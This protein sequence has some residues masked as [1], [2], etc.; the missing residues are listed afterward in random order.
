MAR[1]AIAG[2]VKIDLSNISK[3]KG[4]LLLRLLRDAG[5]ILTTEPQ[6]DYLI[7]IDHNRRDYNA[8]IANGGSPSRSILIRLE[9]PSVFPSQ[10]KNSISK[11]YAQII[12]PGS[13]DTS[14][15]SN[16]QVGWPY[17]YH[18]NPNY[19][20]DSGP[21][22][23]SVLDM[24][25]SYLELQLRN[26]KERDIFVSMIASNKVSP[27]RNE[28]YSIR[29]K[30]AVELKNPSPAVYGPLWKGNLIVK[31]HHRLAV[32]YFS[33]RQGVLP[34][35]R[36]IYGSLFRKYP[37]AKGPI[38]NKHV[39]LQQSKFTLVVE[40]SNITVTEKLF[41]ALV[42]GAVP[43]Y[44]GPDLS[45]VGLPEDIALHCDGDPEQIVENLKKVSQSEIVTILKAGQEFLRSSLFKNTWTEDA[46]YKRI[47]L[48]VVSF[49]ESFKR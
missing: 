34:N 11:K 31:L 22:L 25:M 33:L 38:P 35:P 19:P 7:A 21:N 4:Y 40:N 3:G 6:A 14:P 42:N 47:F 43:I 1:I 20:S 45:K 27:T 8:F 9:P 5:H 23:S 48:E 2:S 16:F 18:L 28:N 17:E 30:I 26:W 37:N 39:I 41:D 10:Y 36:S 32:A 44:I 24:P 29:R 46:V 49:M 12:S 13:I 15:S